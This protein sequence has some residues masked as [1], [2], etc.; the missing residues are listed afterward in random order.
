MEK[1]LKKLVRF[2][3]LYADGIC[4]FVWHKEINILDYLFYCG[5]TK[6][7][8]VWRKIL[9]HNREGTIFTV[10]LI[11]KTNFHH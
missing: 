11:I 9:A 5:Y 7:N 1:D 3:F 2:N 6:L 10:L 8:Y 4:N